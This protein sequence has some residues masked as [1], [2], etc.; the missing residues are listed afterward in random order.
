MHVSH[1]GSCFVTFYNLNWMLLRIILKDKRSSWTLNFST[2]LNWPK[3]FHKNISPHDL[4]KMILARQGN[5]DGAK[6]FMTAH[7]LSC[8]QVVSN[9]DVQNFRMIWAELNWNSRKKTRFCTNQL[10]RDYLHL[11]KSTDLKIC[12]LIQQLEWIFWFYLNPF[13]FKYNKQL[14]DDI[15]SI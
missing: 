7:I 3:S 6:K 9:F 13:F 12:N 11:G 2:C 1:A 14:F 15:Y 10:A 4:Y 8:Y 5:A